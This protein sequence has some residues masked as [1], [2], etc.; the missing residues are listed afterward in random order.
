MVHPTDGNQRNVIDL[1]MFFLQ[2]QSRDKATMPPP[3][4]KVKAVLIS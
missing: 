4:S 1:L 2:G 3:L